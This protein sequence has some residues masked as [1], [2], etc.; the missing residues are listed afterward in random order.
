[1]NILAYPKTDMKLGTSARRIG[2]R[3]DVGFTAIMG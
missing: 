3:T 1:M 2:T